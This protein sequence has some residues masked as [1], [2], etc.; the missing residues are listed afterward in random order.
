MSEQCPKCGN[1]NFRLDFINKKVICN[2][3]G[4][5]TMPFPKIRKQPVRFREVYNETT[6][7]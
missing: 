5:K 7:N 4:D 2:M 6:S 1:A 3:C